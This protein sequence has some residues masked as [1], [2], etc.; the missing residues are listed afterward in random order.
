[1]SNLP[2]TDL[3]KSISHQSPPVLLTSEKVSQ[4]VGGLNVMGELRSMFRSL[5]KEEAVQ[6]PQ[7]LTLLPNDAGDFITYLGALKEAGVFG[8]KLSP[9]LVTGDKPIITAWTYLMSLETGQP[10]LCC[11]SAELTT[12]RT[13]ATSALAVDYLAAK[14]SDSVAIIG[15]GAIAQA[16]LRY[17]KSLRDWKSIRVFSPSLAGNQQKIDAFKAI[18]P[19]VTI[20][21]SLSQTVAGANVIMLC[22]S[23]GLPVINMA[24]INPGVLITSIST[25]VANA[26]EVPPSLLCHAD[27]YCDYK[28]TTPASAGEMKLAQQEL[29]WSTENIKGDLPDLANE[30]CDLPDYSKPIFFRSLGL[31]LEDIAIAHAV[32]KQT[33]E[34]N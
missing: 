1:M 19:G 10:L 18:D 22:T 27:V 3:P 4:L 26:H 14:D 32:W 24:D 15:S 8:A 11:D 13:A 29:S 34:S 33:Q 12:E 2:K 17:V 6:P 28:L 20:A 21:E 7:S 9:Y 30:Q 23:S 31:G 25:N 16:H 5:G